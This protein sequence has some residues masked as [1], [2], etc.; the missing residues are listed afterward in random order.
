MNPELEKIESY[1]QEAAKMWGRRADFA[2]SREFFELWEKITD[3]RHFVVEGGSI[4]ILGHEVKLA[5]KE[6]RRS[7]W[8][9]WDP[10]ATC[11]CLAL[12]CG[13]KCEKIQFRFTESG[14]PS[15]TKS[16][17]PESNGAVSSEGDLLD[18]VYDV[19][20]FL[21]KN[22]PHTDIMR[23]SK[24]Q[25]TE[26]LDAVKRG[27]PAKVLAALRR[28]R[29][30][31]MKDLLAKACQ[32]MRLDEL[33]PQLTMP[34]DGTYSAAVAVQPGLGV[35]QEKADGCQRAATIHGKTTNTILRELEFLLE[36]C[37]LV[38]KGEKEFFL[39]LK[40]AEIL[41]KDKIGALHVATLR[42]GVGAEAP[43]M[44]GGSL[45]VIQK[46]VPGRGFGKFTVDLLDGGQAYG[47]FEHDG[48]LALIDGKPLD[49]LLAILP[50]SPAALIASTT[51]MLRDLVKNETTAL[52]SPAFQ[53]AI[54]LRASEFYDGEAP[55]TVVPEGLDDSQARAW[56]SAIDGRN[57]V[58]LIQGPPG[59]GKT[60][61]LEKIV[62]SLCGVG[63]R[64]ILT[65]PSNTA[66][67]NICAKLL[68]LPIVRVGGMRES[69]LPEVAAKCWHADQENFVGFT[70]KRQR[71]NGSLILAGTH[72][73]IMKSE[74]VR[75]E[76][77]EHGFLDVALFDEA[78]MSRV[79]EFLP[80]ARLAKRAALLGDHKQ[81]PPFPL[82]AE[83]LAA[84]R[85]THGVLPGA[86]LG[87]VQKSAM[88][89]LCECRGFPVTT[90]SSSYRCQHPRL[91]R[92]S[93]T[94]FYNAA[95][96]AGGNA[97]YL[98]L[99]YQQIA[100]KYPP[101]TLSLL[102]TSG[103]P[104]AARAERL[105]IEGGRPGLENPLEAN[106]CAG[107][108]YQSIAK[109]PLSEISII[110]PY[111]RQARLIRSILSQR[112]A[113]ELIGRL[114]GDAEWREFLSARVST[115]D[116]F[117]GG[118]S[119]VII[120]SYVRSNNAGGVGFVDDPNRINVAHTRARRE[121]RVVCD[122]ECL[123]RCSASGIFDK[124]LKAFQRDGLVVAVD[125]AYLEAMSQRL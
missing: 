108:F 110:T 26:A 119:D 41:Q 77:E 109:Y 113:G 79:E 2:R 8:I 121:M 33:S 61:V 70:E 68:D 11:A 91:I 35:S 40:D 57:D 72:V 75:L 7:A 92:L 122:I 69:V 25:F 97:E 93:S 48:D 18:A 43:L 49:G 1:F 73:G 96:K 19:I 50:H 36:T 94:L 107:L 76:L 42:I 116:A 54:G 81:L 117:Q 29:R 62:R 20:A 9:E 58:V 85:S 64:L 125:N 67:D 16:A 115:V 84:L 88:E 24:K 103:L 95:V 44:E 71:F 46:G 6:T 4:N 124:M 102:D 100:E 12:E 52:M 111:R 101:S 63:A 45:R 32:D 118:E 51:R 21:Q 34:L 82:S 123:R 90:L 87:L 17:E 86:L 55:T 114:V 78:G 74:L 99:D 39:A 105:V 13:S 30:P 15:I 106:I 14:E 98:N 59:T 120:I 27:H 22:S 112:K 23:L 65:A 3:P 31:E 28:L 60:Y 5:G 83:V 38:V 10:I 53:A 56:R 89:W 37:E 47:R 104:D 80:C 66:V